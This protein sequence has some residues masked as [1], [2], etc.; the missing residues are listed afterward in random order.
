MRIS[1][2]T[3]IKLI[4]FLLAISKITTKEEKK[5]KSYSKRILQFFKSTASGF[6]FPLWLQI[7]TF[8]FLILIILVSIVLIILWSKNNAGPPRLNPMVIQTLRMEGKLPNLG[9]GVQNIGMMDPVMMKR[10]Q[11]MRALNSSGVNLNQSGGFY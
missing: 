9:M 10:M 8:I 2:I 1:K 6:R 7:V 3:M 4:I 11:Q 5:Q